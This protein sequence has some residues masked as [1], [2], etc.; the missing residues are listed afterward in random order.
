MELTARVIGRLGDLDRRRRAANERRLA[1]AGRAWSFAHNRAWLVDGVRCAEPFLQVSDASPGS[2]LAW[3]LAQLRELGC[4][5]VGPWWLPAAWLVA[6]DGYRWL[7]RLVARHVLARRDGGDAGDVYVPKARAELEPL[8]ALWPFVLA[9]PT[10]RALTIDELIRARAWPVHPLG[11]VGAPAHAD[12]RKLS[13]A[14]FFCHD[15]DHAR[16]KVREDLAALGVVIPDAYRDGDTFDAVRGVHRTVL[17]AA[18]RYVDGDGWRQGA[19]RAARARRWLCAIAR[20]PRR[21][22]A[23]AARWLLFELVHEKSLPL[24]R[25]VLARALASASPDNP[26]VAKLRHKCEAGFYP[27]HGPSPAAVGA[28]GEARAWLRSLVEHG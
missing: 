23:E 22:L 12:G 9:L 21:P 1:D 19:V 26:H 5:R 3:E 15:V 7:V 28:L 8:L 10:S 20:E 25:A 17:P 24:E 27:V 13:P 14:E 4:V 16:F 18:R 6:P 11:V 2:V